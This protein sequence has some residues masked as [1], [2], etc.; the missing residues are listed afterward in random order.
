MHY[1]LE[2]TFKIIALAPQ[3]RVTDASGGSVC[4]VRQKMFRLRE[5]VEVFTDDTRT[6]RLA[7]INADRIIDFSAN[8][9]FSS[10]SGARMGAIRRKGMRSIWRAHYEI[11]DGNEVEFEIREDNGWIKVLDGF[12]SEIPLLGAFAGYFFNPTYRVTRARTG[13]LVVAIRKQPAFWEGR[14]V[15]D[16]VGQADEAEQLRI[17]LGSLMMVLLERQRG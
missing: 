10:I 16:Q 2:L 9:S 11:L 3:L 17:M 5:A 4:Y 1:P 6:E 7:E 15:L 14:F 8:Y 12:F 13:E